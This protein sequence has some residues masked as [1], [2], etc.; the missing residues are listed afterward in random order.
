MTRACLGFL[1]VSFVVACGAPPPPARVV[2]ANQ[3]PVALLT[4][5]GEAAAGMECAFDASAS[6][7]VDGRLVSWSLSFGDD[8]PPEVLA[9]GSAPTWQHQYQ[10]AGRFV[11]QLE[12]TD[13]GGLIGRARLPLEVAPPPDSGLPTL[14]ALE[15]TQ[16]GAAL[17]EG[18]RVAAGST[19]DVTVR[20]S[21]AE[22][23]LESA[24]VELG[25]TAVSVDVTAG[26][27]ISGGGAAALGVPATTGAAVLRASALDRYG[28][29][30]APR[31]HALLVVDAASDSDGDGLPDLVDPAPDVENG[32]LAEA[33]LLGALFDDGTIPT[34]L[35]GN[36]RAERVLEELDE[37]TPAASSSRPAGW[38]THAPS[39]A[40]LD[41]LVPGAPA[42]PGGFVVRYT[43]FLEPPPNADAVVIEIEADDLG[44]VLLGGEVVA[45]ADEEYASDFFRF[46]RAPS[47][48]EELPIDG[49]TPVVIVV[50]DGPEAPTSWSV[51]FDF[52]ANGQSVLVPEAV[53][54]AS[55]TVR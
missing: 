44:V 28:N 9:E 11:V 48:T 52:R 24:L 1:V 29:R 39:A 19:L 31:E 12:V 14:D 4:L 51:R 18:A 5:P 7:D 37:A 21:D 10:S 32:L 22:G 15:L 6:L 40:V 34:D 3:Q 26:G 54:I 49:R 33:F 45:S 53:G 30:S 41:E 55:F 8:T 17:A 23:N 42:A 13:D 36:Q 47:R 46:D 27:G 20:A 50:G 2:V 25:E 16:N 43:G 35:F 38:L